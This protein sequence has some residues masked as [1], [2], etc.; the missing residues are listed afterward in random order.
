MNFNSNI[1]ILICCFFAICFIIWLPILLLT[2]GRKFDKL[3]KDRRPA[4]DPYI[5][6]YS[7]GLRAQLYAACCLS[8]WYSSHGVAKILY[9]DY[10]FVKNSN[11]K[12]KIISGIYCFIMA[13]MGISMLLYYLVE[14]VIPFIIKLF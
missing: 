1:L 5:P 12:D 3:F 9:H 7:A 14:Y 8:H 6:I 13:G 4:Y 10:D 2:V 11:R